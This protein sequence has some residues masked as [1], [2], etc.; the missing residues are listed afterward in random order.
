MRHSR[1]VISLPH[2]LNGSSQRDSNIVHHVQ[3][4]CPQ[5]FAVPQMLHA[6]LYVRVFTV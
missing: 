3:P 1:P 6:A 5:A 4:R 2:P